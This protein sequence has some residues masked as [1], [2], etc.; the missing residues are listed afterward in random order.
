MLITIHNE[1]GIIQVF[2][3][4]YLDFP[5][6]QKMVLPMEKRSGRV[7]KSFYGRLYNL[8]TGNKSGVAVKPNILAKNCI[9]MRGLDIVAKI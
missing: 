4:Q 2:C 8:Y 1:L 3:Y 7:D 5:S 6:F 9:S